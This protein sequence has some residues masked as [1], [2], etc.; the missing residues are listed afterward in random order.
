V[1]NITAF[2]QSNFSVIEIMWGRSY[3]ASTTLVL[4]FVLDVVIVLLPGS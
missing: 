2:R 3:M 4:Q 1:V